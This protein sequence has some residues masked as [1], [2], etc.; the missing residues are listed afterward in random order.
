MKRFIFILSFLLLTSCNLNRNLN[1][2]IDATTGL[3]ALEE[4]QQAV[5]DLALAQ[6]QEIF[7]QNMALGT[8][9]SHGP[10]L[11]EHLIDDWAFD[12]AHN[13]RQ[14]IDELPENQCQS[15]RQDTT[16]HFIEFDP[17]GQ[18]IRSQ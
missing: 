5:R 4:G 16:H 2:T 17:Q 15:Y 18:L 14:R 13:P 9:L 12:I 3:G 11:A 1:N 10:C 6:A 8:D 7:Q